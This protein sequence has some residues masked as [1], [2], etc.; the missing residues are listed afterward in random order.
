MGLPAVW[1][2]VTPVPN[3]HQGD[4]GQDHLARAPTVCEQAARDGKQ[5]HGQK[6]CGA[7]EASLEAVQVELR[8]NVRRQRANHTR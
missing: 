3:R 7:Q 4:A 5:R 1:S 6:E 2:M 8:D